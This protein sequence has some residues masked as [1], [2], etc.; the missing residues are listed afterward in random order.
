MNLDQLRDATRHL[1]GT[2]R[3]V[4]IGLHE[5]FPLRA[6]S[7]AHGSL[8]L[9]RSASS[10]GDGLLFAEDSHPEP[11]PGPD[12]GE[13][14]EHVE[15]LPAVPQGPWTAGPVAFDDGGDDPAAPLDGCTTR[16]LPNADEGIE[17]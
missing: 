5:I 3:L 10:V 9:H 11:E 6:A 13:V 12:P 14:S 1:P 2:T 15:P 16:Y 4:G 17:S 8:F 7:A